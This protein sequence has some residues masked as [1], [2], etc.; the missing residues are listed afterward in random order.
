MVI[1]LQNMCCIVDWIFQELPDG[2]DGALACA[3]TAVAVVQSRV[4]SIAS[5]VDLDNAAVEI[6]H[7]TAAL[8]QEIL[9]IRLSRIVSKRS[10]ETH[11]LF[12]GVLPERPENLRFVETFNIDH[13]AY[14]QMNRID[15]M[16]RGELPLSSIHLC[17]R[18]RSIM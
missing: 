10:E 11:A 17:Y 3:F 5:Q 15:I 1:Y 7:V 14:L 6:V 4:D 9:T 8:F 12:V 16:R 13:F 2:I 18:V